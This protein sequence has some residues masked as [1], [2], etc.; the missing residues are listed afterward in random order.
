MTKI[1]DTLLLLALPASGKSEVRKYLASLSPEQCREDLHLGPTVQLDDFPYVHLM[2]RTDDELVKLGSARA[3]FEAPDRSFLE[4]RDWGTLIELIN[5]DHADAV[6]RRPMPTGPA[7]ERILG[8]VEKAAERVGV[9][10]R[11]AKLPVEVRRTV[12][13]ALDREAADLERDLQATHVPLEGHTLVI[14][15]ARG[16]AE[17]SAMPLTAPFGYGYSLARFAPAILE[18]ATILYVWV[19]P[20]DSRRKNRERANPD[21]PGSILHH[22]VPEYVMKNDYGCDDMGWL[23]D[24][25]DKP[26]TVRVAAHGKTYHLPVARF[27]NRKDLTTFV[28]G[29]RAKWRPEDVR[30]LH[31][32]LAGALR[33]L[34]PS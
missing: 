26:G 1:I 4:P 33:K 10:P 18:R 16:G 29:D 14:E 13:H 19:T 27:D 11:L 21:D 3:F 25:S 23:I 6:A 17:S 15:A 9:A 34:A 30:A 7:G 31:D 2:R 32:G 28:R 12:A 24:S 5:D 8:R 22:G 20:E